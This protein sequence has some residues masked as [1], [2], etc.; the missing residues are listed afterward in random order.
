MMEFPHYDAAAVSE[1]R[2]VVER[3]VGRDLQD[4]DGFQSLLAAIAGCG[5][6]YAMERSAAPDTDKLEKAVS[7]AQSLRSRLRSLGKEIPSGVLVGFMPVE[8]SGDFGHDVN[9]AGQR[10]REWVSGIDKLIDGLEAEISAR[11]KLPGRPPLAARNVLWAML[12]RLWRRDIEGRGPGKTGDQWSGGVVDFIAA[13]S[14]PVMEEDEIAPGKI[15]DFLR[16]QKKEAK[17][18]RPWI[19]YVD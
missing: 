11:P 10:A 1:I 3:E 19:G 2:A 8:R 5:F 15:G 14:R 16:K 4:D 6:T 18:K 17:K 12:E 7:A 13:C 9:T